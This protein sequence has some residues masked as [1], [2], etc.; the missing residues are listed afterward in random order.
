MTVAVV[1]R[2]SFDGNRTCVRFDKDSELDAAIALCK[3]TV[4][5][6]GQ[7]CGETMTLKP[8]NDGRDVLPQP[9]L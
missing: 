3:K 2:P 5:D 6:L 7:V 8:I 9:I 1:S 4:E